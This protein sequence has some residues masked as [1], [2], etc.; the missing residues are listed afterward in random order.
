[1]LAA[2]GTAQAVRTGAVDEGE[3]G[4]VGADLDE[5]VVGGDVEQPQQVGMPL[6][7]VKQLPLQAAAIVIVEL[8]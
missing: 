5:A 1:M 7:D 8:P 3:E 2:A 6:L 4:Q